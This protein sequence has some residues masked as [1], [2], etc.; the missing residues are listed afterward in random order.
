MR[1][2]PLPDSR[3]DAEPRFIDDYLAY[4]LAQ[5]SQRISDEFHSEVEAA[6]LSVTEWR[7]LASLKGS[8]GETVG[9][10]ARLA[11]TKQPTLSKV[12]QRLEADGLVT[13]AGV[14]RDRRQTRVMITRK[15]LALIQGLCEQAKQ[16]QR[17]V[18][19]PFGEKK[20]ALLLEML[21]VLMSAQVPFERDTQGAE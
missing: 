17:A 4:R 7:V 8:D 12:V 15:G 13:R 1:S 19:A 9:T 21:G 18:L 11:I 10:L 20:A 6:G 3:D 16:H 14:R 2:D 5:A